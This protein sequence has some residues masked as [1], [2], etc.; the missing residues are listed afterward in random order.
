MLASRAV[1]ATN[2]GSGSAVQGAGCQFHHDWT[3][4]VAGNVCNGLPQSLKLS[5]HLVQ[6]VFR[7]LVDCWAGE[8]LVW[9]SMIHNLA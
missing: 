3:V 6:F 1:L 9:H 8:V 5:M 2:A 4:T 7:R